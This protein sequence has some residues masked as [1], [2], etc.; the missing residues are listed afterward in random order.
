MECK[1]GREM[2]QGVRKS[3]SGNRRWEGCGQNIDGGGWGVGCRACPE[4]AED[5]IQSPSLTHIQTSQEAERW[6][7]RMKEE[8]VG[9]RGE[10]CLES[11]TCFKSQ[12]VQ[13]WR[14]L[15]R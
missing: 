14:A 1:S 12:G 8:E 15:L 6:R 2:V 9:K 10:A 4:S 11:R 7:R 5:S 3:H 13:R